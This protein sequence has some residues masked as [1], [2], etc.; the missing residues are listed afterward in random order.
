MMEPLETLIAAHVW[1][2]R[3]TTGR[4][5]PVNSHRSRSLPQR[6]VGETWRNVLCC[7]LKSVLHKATA[8]WLK[9]RNQTKGIKILLCKILQV[10][11]L[12]PAGGLEKV[13][14]VAD[15]FL[16]E[17]L[18]KRCRRIENSFADRSLTR[19]MLVWSESLCQNL[20][21]WVHHFCKSE[22]RLLLELRFESFEMLGKTVTSH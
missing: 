19:D 20:E 2:F 16:C 21:T 1:S 3:V 5:R 15:A 13:R 7:S 18:R 9:V 14:G 22:G 6:D 10:F 12:V 17:I 11:V 8:S 4:S